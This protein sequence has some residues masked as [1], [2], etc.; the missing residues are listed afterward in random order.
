MAKNFPSKNKIISRRANQTKRHSK[1]RRHFVNTIFMRIKREPIKISAVILGV[2]L[3][4]IVTVLF[5]LYAKDESIKKD[6]IHKV[7]SK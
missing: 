6:Q 3:L 2:I 1:K 5:L 7:Q 4:I